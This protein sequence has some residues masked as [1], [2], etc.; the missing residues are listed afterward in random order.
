MNGFSGAAFGKSSS[1]RSCTKHYEVQRDN[2]HLCGG[3][4]IVVPPLTILG[5]LMV[6]RVK[7][8][9]QVQRWKHLLRSLDA[10]LG[11]GFSYR[12]GCKTMLSA[13]DIYWRD[14]EEGVE[15]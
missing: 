4:G 11:H 1:V 15:E 7:T 14:T 12:N 3:Q 10:M 5:A 2:L 9:D 13:N 6:S 8:S